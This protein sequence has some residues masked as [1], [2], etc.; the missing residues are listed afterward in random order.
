YIVGEIART[1]PA[2]VRAIHEAGH[3]IGSHSWDHRRVHRFTPDSFRE[4]LLRS[5]DAL[6]QAAGVSVSGF[7]APTFSVVRETGW[8]VDILAECGFEYDSSIFPVRHDRYG[9]PDAPRMP[10]L[11]VGNEREILEFPLLTYRLAGLNLPVA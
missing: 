6:E 7:R 8:A 4:D 3:E 2:L 11:A 10:F 9:I 5:K 1:H